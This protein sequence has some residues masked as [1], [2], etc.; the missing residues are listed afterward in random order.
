LVKRTFAKYCRRMCWTELW[1]HLSCVYPKGSRALRYLP[2]RCL[3]N[4][5][6]AG[7]FLSSNG[8]KKARRFI[9]RRPAFIIVIY[10][11]CVTP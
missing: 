1:K 2:P 8:K 10:A 4:R 3:A 7:V 9:A 6:H 5:A 11:R